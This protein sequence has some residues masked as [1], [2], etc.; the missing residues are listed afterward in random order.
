MYVVEM[1]LIYLSKYYISFPLK[2]ILIAL[3]WS[4]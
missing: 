4:F 1:M 3:I 2:G